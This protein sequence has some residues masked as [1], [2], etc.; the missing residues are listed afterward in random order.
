MDYAR[1]KFG[2][3]RMK[4]EEILN[5]VIKKLEDATKQKTIRDYFATKHKIEIDLT[6]GKVSKRVKMAIE[7]MGKSREELKKG[8]EQKT[9]QCKNKADSKDEKK[10][11]STKR[12]PREKTKKLTLTD[13]GEDINVIVQEAQDLFANLEEQIDSHEKY[14]KTKDTVSKAKPT[15]SRTQ[16][17][18]VGNKPQTSRARRNTT[19]EKPKI[20]RRNKSELHT[21]EVIPQREKDKANALKSKLKAIEIYR[22]S[23]IEGKHEKKAR[24]VRQPKEDAELS[25]SSD[26]S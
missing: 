6:E 4:S 16:K 10:P 25:E 14:L 20:Q 18:D 26:S 1:E 19:E 8:E 11:K 17:D 3:T 24:K 12:K 15:S 13:D 5:P 22:K 7:K 21:K 23:K 2:W 9:N